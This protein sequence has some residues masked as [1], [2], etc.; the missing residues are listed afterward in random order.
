MRP[1]NGKK[2]WTENATDAVPWRSAQRGAKDA[3]K[4]R[5][6]SFVDTDTK[7]VTR[8]KEGRGV[9]TEAVDPSYKLQVHDCNWRTD[10]KVESNFGNHASYTAGDATQ[11]MRYSPLS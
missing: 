6:R 3:Q 9:K 5:Y 10:L 2:N 7:V 11:A 4:M 8:M 1:D